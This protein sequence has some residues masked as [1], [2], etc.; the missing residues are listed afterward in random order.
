MEFRWSHIVHLYHV[1]LENDGKENCVQL[2][3]EELNK[4]F[5]IE[6]LNDTYDRNIV[7]LNSLNIRC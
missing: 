1:F 2:I 4:M 7:G 5:G 3:E 6:S